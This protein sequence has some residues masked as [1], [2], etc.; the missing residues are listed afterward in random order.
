MINIYIDGAARPNPGKG[1]IGVVIRGDS[2]DYT[3][4]RPLTTKVTSN[5]AEYLALFAVLDE[6]IKNNLHQKEIT[7]FSDSQMMVEQIKGERE[8]LGGAYAK[9]YNLVK[10][11]LPLFENLKFEWIPREENA[12]ANLL[13]VRA[14]GGRE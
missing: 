3:I 9:W 13:A 14:I 12:E 6:L 1:G 10:T 2:W 11:L 4:S 8:V 7:I 5:E